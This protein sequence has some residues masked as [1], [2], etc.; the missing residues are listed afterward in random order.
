MSA[1]RAA[2]ERLN[3]LRREEAVAELLKCCGSQ[4]WTASMVDARPF[5]SEQHVFDSAEQIFKGLAQ[6]DWL[7]AFRHHPKIGGQKAAVEV[8]ADAQRWSEQEQARSADAG[9]QVRA[10]LERANAQYE[11]RFGYFFIV[12]ASSKSAEEMLAILKSRMAN[13]PE[14]ELEAA[15]GEQAKITQLR[16]KRMLDL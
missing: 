6:R 8:S 7:E 11:S 1:N 3:R 9:A 10:G 2:L 16:L 12:C 14:K 13:Q 15:A 4:K 5:Q